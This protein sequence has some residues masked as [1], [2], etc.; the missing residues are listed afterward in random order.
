MTHQYSYFNSKYES[1]LLQNTSRQMK[2]QI[3][4]QKQNFIPCRTVRRLKTEMKDYLC[5]ISNCTR[6]LW[7]IGYSEIVF[8][9]LFW[10]ASQFMS[11]DGVNWFLWEAYISLQKYFLLFWCFEIFFDVDVWDIFVSF[12]C[13]DVLRYFYLTRSSI[14]F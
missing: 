1:V 4:T 3:Y 10:F 7:I 2:F 11:D 14:V 9:C 5:W 12:C 8:Q 13:F 6:P